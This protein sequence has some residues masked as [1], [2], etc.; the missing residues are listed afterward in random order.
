MSFT[1]AYYVTG[2]SLVKHLPFSSLT[3]NSCDLIQGYYFSMLVP[4]IELNEFIK[5]HISEGH[6]KTQVEKQ[7]VKGR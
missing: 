7:P 1:E 5:S 6:G 2:S 4:E 3:E